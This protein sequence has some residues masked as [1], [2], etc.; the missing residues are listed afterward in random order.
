MST[1]KPIQG[2]VGPT[3]FKRGDSY[4]KKCQKGAGDD[5]LSG[6]IAKRKDASEG[7]GIANF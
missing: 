7:R 1:N 3:D 5:F 4:I 6:R 2:I